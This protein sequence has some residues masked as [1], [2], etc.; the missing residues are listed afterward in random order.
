MKVRKVGIRAY[1]DREP[2]RGRDYHFR[3]AGCRRGRFS[4]WQRGPALWRSSTNVLQPPVPATMSFLNVLNGTSD[5]AAVLPLQSNTPFKKE[6]SAGLA[7]IRLKCCIRKY[8]GARSLPMTSTRSLGQRRACFRPNGLC[9]SPSSTKFEA[10][11]FM[12]LRKYLCAT[13][14][15]SGD[16]CV[17]F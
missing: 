14:D 16:A 10:G 4:T 15:H 7:C 2:R 1:A 3:Y 17:T 11:Q 13:S 8:W 12:D 9:N 5:H 6:R